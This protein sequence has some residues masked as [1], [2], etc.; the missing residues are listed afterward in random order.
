MKDNNNNRYSDTRDETEPFVSTS[1]VERTPVLASTFEGSV[2]IERPFS[3]SFEMVESP[4]NIPT[5]DSN[6]DDEIVD[7]AVEVASNPSSSTGSTPSVIFLSDSTATRVFQPDTEPTMAMPPLESNQGEDRAMVAS[8]VAGMV[9]GLLLFGPIVGAIVGFGTAYATKTEGPAGD[10]ARA[11]GDIARAI[12]DKAIELDQKHHLV[13]KSKDVVVA[14]WEKAKALDQ[15]HQ[16]LVKVKDFVVFSWK[17]TVEFTR[18]HRLLERGVQGVGRGF[19][20]LFRKLFGNTDSTNG[21]N[22]YN[23]RNETTSGP[24]YRGVPNDNHV[25]EAMPY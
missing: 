12:G 17:E 10:I 16:I 23:N 2:I 6:N 25:P 19:E 18:R 21:R 14:G 15:E 5:A 1:L 11:M 22:N 8:G 4:S 24:A 7:A 13:E 3:N 20:W 9:V